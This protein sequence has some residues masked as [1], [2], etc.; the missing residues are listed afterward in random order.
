MKAN[1]DIAVDVKAKI[2]GLG[3]IIRDTAGEIQVSSYCNLRT[4]FQPAIAEAM[5]LMNAMIICND[6]GFAQVIFERDCKTILKAANSTQENWTKLSPLI[7]D[8][9]CMVMQQNPA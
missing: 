4:R 5:A 1:W 2:T 9:R 7:H 6:L 3:V 8:I